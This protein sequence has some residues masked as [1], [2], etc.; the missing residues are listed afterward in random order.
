MHEEQTVIGQIPREALEFERMFAQRTQPP[1]ADGLKAGGNASSSNPPLPAMAAPRAL[2]VNTPVVPP[3]EPAVII[4]DRPVA[5]PE[6]P[7]S[8]ID[9]TKKA[10]PQAF[11]RSEPPTVGERPVRDEPTM[12]SSAETT[13]PSVAK[14]V[15]A[16]RLRVGLIALLLLAVL[17]L[18]FVI[19]TPR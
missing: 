19:R 8:V 14:A 2:P 5:L 16:R 17:L 18:V 13:E 12:I 4:S 10:S 7:E 9:A 11:A 1:P 6:V 3:G 15:T